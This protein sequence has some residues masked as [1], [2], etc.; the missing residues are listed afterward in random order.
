[1][2]ERTWGTRWWPN[3]VFAFLLGITEVNVNLAMAKLYYSD[4]LP[5]LTFR[6]R[7]AKELIENHYRIAEEN[8]KM[9]RKSSRLAASLTHE[10][11]HLPAG[12][13]FSGA[14]MVKS[15][16]KY[17]QRKCD[18]CSR[19]IRTYCKCT[20]GV[21]RCNQCFTLHLTQVNCIDLTTD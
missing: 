11:V 2:I 10:L 4:L 16:I 13:K 15:L 8:L 20:P 5:Q 9:M 7:L 6:K 14:R 17:P 1:M 18:G 19:K 3:R 12:K 21:H